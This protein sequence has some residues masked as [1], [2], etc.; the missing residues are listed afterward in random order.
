MIETKDI[1]NKNSDCTMFSYISFQEVH[2]AIR[3]LELFNK[4]K[5]N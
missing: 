3:K 4:R 5:I 2:S 1:L